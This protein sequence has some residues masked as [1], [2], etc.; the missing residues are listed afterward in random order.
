MK[1][2]VWET[3][4]QKPTYPQD[5]GLTSFVKKSIDKPP[6]NESIRL[7]EIMKLFI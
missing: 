1:H 6:R 7:S 5:I 3:S 4:Y 2:I